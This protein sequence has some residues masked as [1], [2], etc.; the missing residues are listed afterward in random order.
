MK[1]KTIFL[2]TAVA[3][4][5]VGLCA[6]A[7]QPGPRE[8]A[9]AS[10]SA[11]SEKMWSAISCRA[12]LYLD[13]AEGHTPELTWSD[14]WAL[15]S[16]RGMGLVCG[17]ERAD[18]QFSSIATA[19]DRRVGAGIFHDRCS[20]CHG[21]DGSGGSVGPSLTRAGYDHGDSDLAVYQVL[22]SGIPGTAMPP[23]SC[24]HPRS[25]G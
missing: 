6:T 10:G 15:S 19:D 14:L 21:N 12:W 3:V 4:V 1:P 22:R 24:R 13:K 5:L 11:S 2:L 7:L 25:C 9:E 18:L 23:S 20:G 16:Q 8:L 17:E